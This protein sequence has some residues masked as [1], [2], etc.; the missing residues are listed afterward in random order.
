MVSATE[1][2]LFCDKCSDRASDICLVIPI[3]PDTSPGKDLNTY[4][5]CFPEKRLF[6]FECARVQLIIFALQG[7]K[8]LVVTLLDH[9]PVV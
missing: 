7:D 9:V 4:N 6:E 1:V 8:L 2:F 3:L 5:V